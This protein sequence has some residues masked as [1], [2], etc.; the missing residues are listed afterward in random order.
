[1]KL[2]IHMKLLG[3]MLILTLIP[4]GILGFLA[5]HDEKALGEKS[6]QETQAMG[7]QVIGDTNKALTNLGENYIK[8]KSYDHAQMVELYIRANP[9]MTLADLQKSDEFQKISVQKVGTLGY[10]ALGDSSTL[11]LR[12]HPNPKMVDFDTHAYATSLPQFWSVIEQSQ[13]GRDASGYYDW[14]EK[15]G[16]IRAKYM[17]VHPVG[18]TTADGVRLAS[19]STTYMDEFSGP[20]KAIETKINSSIKTSVNNIEI[21]SVNTQNTLLIVTVIVILLVFVI[22]FF[23]ASSIT[24]PIKKLTEVANKVSM[25]DMSNTEIT[26][27]SNDEIGELAES[28]KRM[29]VSVKYYMLKQKSH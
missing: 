22:S 28:F 5:L 17:Y 19:F 15:D 11:I 18:V 26:V 3:V 12:F 24:T 14:V 20:S 2:T 10:T 25:G 27:T 23:V 1:M 16:S 21:A 29:V 7:I 4:L 13:G 8:E 6:T 9:K